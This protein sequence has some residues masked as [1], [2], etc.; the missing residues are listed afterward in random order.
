M[1]QK[2]TK[3]LLPIF[4]IATA[5]CSNLQ[6][7]AQCNIPGASQQPKWCMPLIFKDGSGQRDTIYFGYDASASMF[8]IDYDAQFNEYQWIDSTKFAAYFWPNYPGPGATGL[9][10]RDSGWVAEITSYVAPRADIAFRNGQFPL[11]M[12]W[13]NSQFYSD[14]LPN[15][16]PTYLDKP[17]AWLMLSC[18][19]NEPWYH[20]CVSQPYGLNDSFY[21]FYM[22][23]PQGQVFT[24]VFTDSIVFNGSGM[25][26]IQQTLFLKIHLEKME[27]QT[28]LSNL[29]NS[30]II[31]S[32][33]VNNNIK[34]NNINESFH[35]SLFSVNGSLISEGQINQ[36]KKLINVQQ[37]PNCIYLLHLTNGQNTYAF[38]IVKT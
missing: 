38:K 35:Y 1:M 25:L 17:R 16:Y 14:S 6:L 37:L 34:F 15:D 11:T 20:N 4:I 3:Y 22:H 12:Y 5:I 26:T 32:Y 10:P 18:Q 27:V 30:T 13:D 29:D 2:S 7:N 28:G 8:S 36:N 9:Q 23:P 33:L 21:Y 24:D 31:K 19:S